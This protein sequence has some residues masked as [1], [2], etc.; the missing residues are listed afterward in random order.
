MNSYIYF[1]FANNQE[2]FNYLSDL[3]LETIT[4]IRLINSDNVEIYHLTGI[5][6]RVGSIDE[7][8]SEDHINIGMN[9]YL[10]K[11]NN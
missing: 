4:D 1:A 5:V 8:L 11:S 9:V 2:N 7:N 3:G 10:N 6:G